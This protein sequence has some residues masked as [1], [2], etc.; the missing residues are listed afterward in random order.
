MVDRWEAL[1]TE[2]APIDPDPVSPLN[3]KML[4]GLIVPCGLGVGRGEVAALALGQGIET[5][6]T[7]RFGFL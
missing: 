6:R 5:I 7:V 1:E 4:E 2:R 3:V